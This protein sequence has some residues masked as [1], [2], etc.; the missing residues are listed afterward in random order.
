MITSTYE[1]VQYIYGR[2]GITAPA[3]KRLE[4]CQRL[5]M[6]SHSNGDSMQSLLIR[7]FMVIEP[8]I[9]YYCV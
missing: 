6:S 7:L 1:N 4:K 9:L 8:V 2:V 5:W 3:S